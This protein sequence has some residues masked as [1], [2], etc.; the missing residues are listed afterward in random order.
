MIT[1]LYTIRDRK[2]GIYGTPFGSYN[3]DTAIR[4]F[5]GFCN[6]AQNV[7]LADDLELY[8]VGDFNSDSGEVLRFDKPEFICNGV[9]GDL[10]NE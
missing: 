6:Q 4:D 7:Y 2:S 1:K 9:R 3:N 8:F 5:R 10:N